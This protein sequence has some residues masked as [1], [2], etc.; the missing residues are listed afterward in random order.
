VTTL[1]SL[2]SQPLGYPGPDDASDAPFFDIRQTVLT[3]YANSPVLLAIIDALG[4]AIDR[5]PALTDFYDTV[6]NIDTAVGFGLDIWGR[7]VGVRR[8]L[9]IPDESYLG[10][11]EDTL[12]Q[13]FGFGVFYAG[14]ALTPNFLLTDA[15]YRNLILAKAALNITDAAIPSINAILRALFPSYGNVFV[16]DNRNMTMT[17]VFSAVPSKVDYA[18]VTQSGALPRPAGVSV[19]VETP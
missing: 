2:V 5:G 10:F 8:A 11:N 7:I 13:P 15:A 4:T 3:Q 19:T 18:I 9:Y 17:Y 6:W 1:V 12:A 16:R 14:Q